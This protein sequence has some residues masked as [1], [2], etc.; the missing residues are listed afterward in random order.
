MK[1]D[2]ELLRKILF[3]IEEKYKPSAGYIW[4]LKIDGYDMPTV[5]EHCDLLYQQGLVKT[6]KSNYAG[7]KI[8]DFAV[9]NITTK[10]YDYL[11]L[12][13][14]DDI[15]GKTKNEIEEKKLPKTFEA[16]AKIAG[17]FAGNIIKEMNG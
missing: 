4:I 17:I 9:G 14:S 2:M 6:Y 10:G 11:E 3:T 16:I 1:R 8:I 12:I 13:R 7:N 15:W 5:A